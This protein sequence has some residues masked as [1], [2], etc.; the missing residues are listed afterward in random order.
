MF[1]EPIRNNFFLSVFA[2][3]GGIEV[4]TLVIVDDGR[5]GWVD[6]IRPVGDF[7]QVRVNFV[8]EKA[9]MD[10]ESVHTYTPAS[11][12][13]VI[14]YGPNR[15]MELFVSD[16]ELNR[17]IYNRMSLQEKWERINEH[18]HDGITIMVGTNKPL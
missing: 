16:Q 9:P 12:H 2:S 7:T 1:S 15:K 17:T 6:T 4:G 3:S 13:I 11:N 10:I 5:I 18:A 14:D 8:D